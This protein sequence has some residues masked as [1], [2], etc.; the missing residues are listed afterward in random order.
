MYKYFIIFVLV[1]PLT[2]IWLVEGG[3]YAASVGI[4][5]FPN[6][7]SV[8]FAIYATAMVAVALLF[9]ARSR[10]LVEAPVPISGA[11][12]RFRSFSTNLFFFNVAFLIFFL[13]GFGAINVWLGN[14]GKG[15]FRATLG[16]FGA[17]PNLMT[18][19]IVP[20]LFA[21]ASI[22]YSRTSR[23]GT[24][25]LWWLTNL[26]ITFIIGA[27]WGFKSTAMMVLLPGLLLLYWRVRPR[28]LI[29]LAAMFVGTLILFFKIFDAGVEVDADLQTF[30]L[31]R[32]TVLQGDVAWH[33]WGLYS[34]G[35]TFPSYWPT[36]LAGLGD[37][38]LSTLGPAR[39]DTFEWMLYHYDW[40]LTYLAGAQLD[41]IEGGHS[42]TGTP[43]SEGLIAGGL[44]GVALFVLFGG[45]LIGGMYRFLDRS[46]HRRHDVRA[47]IGA[48][49]FCFCV[50]P[51]LNS[52]AVVQLFHV[53]LLISI[54]TT[55]LLLT[56]MRRLR[57]RPHM[58]QK[59]SRTPEPARA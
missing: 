21:Y 18:K 29:T 9:G 24:L 30:L 17:I 3:E 20:A 52:G 25:R 32:I 33:I 7:A 43:F 37:K 13:F 47:V 35:E 51:W 5:G 50:F 4:E 14:I 57:L 48:T 23:R 44:G 22:L 15:E 38:L 39:S 34:T 42:I 41:V 55:L 16:Q 46:L 1:T 58:I 59:S 12:A 10:H 40:M 54:G 26:V 31:R 36:L 49:Y 8:A 28:T 27:S 53:S 56:A 2:G 45:M 11:A 19:F 6:G